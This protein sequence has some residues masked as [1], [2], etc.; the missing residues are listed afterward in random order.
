MPLLRQILL[1]MGYKNALKCPD[2]D[3]KK[4]VGNCKTGYMNILARKISTDPTL[5]A[6]MPSAFVSLIRKLKGE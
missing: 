5:A 2:D 1:E 6:R 4:Q 3:F